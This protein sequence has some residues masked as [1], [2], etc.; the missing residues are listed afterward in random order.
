M[1]NFAL[2]MMNF[3]LKTMDFVLKTGQRIQRPAH[4]VRLRADLQVRVAGRAG[5]CARH[6]GGGAV[7]RLRARASE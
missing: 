4:C 6:A 3:V 5:L 7:H 1:M 2:E